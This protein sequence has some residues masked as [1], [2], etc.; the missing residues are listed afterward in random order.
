MA[1]RESHNIEF[2]FG[3]ARNERLLKLIQEPLAQARA[4]REKTGKRARAWADLDYQ[5]LKSWSRV[6]RVVAKTEVRAS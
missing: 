1:W 4:E 3:L 5:T 2:I 6:R